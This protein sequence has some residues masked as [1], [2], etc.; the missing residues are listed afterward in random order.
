MRIHAFTVAAG[1]YA[2]K[3]RALL[4]SLRRHHPEWR[5]HFAVS[6]DALPEAVSDGFEVDEIHPLSSLGI[7]NL[8]RWVFCHSL[9]ELATAIK[10]FVLKKL[11][12][13]EDCDAVV[14][15]DPDIAVFSPLVDVVQAVTT[16]DIVVTP[17]VTS[18]EKN[19]AGIVAN[20]IPTLQHGIYN[21]GF[22]AVAARDEGATFAAWWADRTY[23]YCR[24]DIPDGIYTDQRWV[25]LAPAYFDRVKVLRSPALNAAPWN[26]STRTLSGDV[27]A[28]FAVDGVPLGFF[29][30]SQLGVMED[31][32]TSGGQAAGHKLIAWY[33][34]QTAPTPAEQA[35]RAAYAFNIFDDGTPIS[36]EQRLVYR[37]RTDVQC[38]HPDPFA[39]G[40]GSYLAWWRAHARREYPRLFDPNTRA[41]E[42]QALSA[43]STYRRDDEEIVSDETLASMPSAPT[44][45]IVSQVAGLVRKI[46]G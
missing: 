37:A 3:V 23:R 20:E 29:H 9:I 21:L 42:I 17:H 44:A 36:M 1:N 13:R 40:P 26:L 31:S 12:A 18:P 41:A 2:P 30:F 32:R 38:A 4:A 24:E 25:D 16:A 35:M 33:R 28:G 43:F 39:A 15:L 10:P 34:E 5:L 11:L 7:P 8:K 19:V 6:D 22:I 14:Y 45:G 27:D 46:R